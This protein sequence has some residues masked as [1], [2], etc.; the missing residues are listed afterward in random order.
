[1][2]TD[3][4]TTRIVRSWLE[5]GVTALPDR[6]L[7]SVLDR[8]P[9]TRQRRSWWPARRVSPMSTQIR[10]AI[11]AAAVVIVAVFGYNLLPRTGNVGPPTPTPSPSPQ[12]LPSQ[13]AIEPGTYWLNAGPTGG[14]G[15]NPLPRIAVT[16][17]A[18]WTAA[19]DL[20]LNNYTPDLNLGELDPSDTGAGPSLVAWQI[21][22]TFVDPCSNLTLVKPTP[23]PGID[24][25]AAALGHQPGTTAGPP[26]A[27]TVGG[28]S[29]KYVELT[30]TADIT[31]CA[32]NFH[33]WASPDG[34]SRWVQ[35]TNEMN[36]IY[37]LD[38]EG[39]RFTFSAR[40][41]GRTTAA[42]RTELETI[43]ASIHIEP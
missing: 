7:D 5:E 9:A 4:D 24:A 29:G 37:I 16:L 34:N 42:D 31:K 13:G 18:G 36:R 43:L 33:I 35:G 27:V 11:A 32:G 25:L 17:P 8:V 10:I 6:V 21:C 14:F 38:V 12:P 41:P 22:G 1:M 26:T 2:S 15:A 28:Y 23:G 20:L 19:G 40:I 39:H 30:V 3:R